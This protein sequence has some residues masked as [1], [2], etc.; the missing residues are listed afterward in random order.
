MTGPSIDRAATAVGELSG[1]VRLLTDEVKAAEALRE[2]KIRWIQRSVIATGAAV[3]VLIILVVANFSLLS[4]TRDAAADAKST[5]DLLLSCFQPNTH[6]SNESIKRSAA[7]LN[8]VRQTQF[9]IA[10]CQRQN[11]LPPN[12]TQAQVDGALGRFQRCVQTYYPGFR[13]PPKASPTPKATP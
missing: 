5:N 13:L 1:S 12:P 7:V 4:H 11:P 8:E 10:V 3:A 2:E 6:C 9:V